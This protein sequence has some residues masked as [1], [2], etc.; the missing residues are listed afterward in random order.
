MTPTEIVNNFY[1]AFEQKDS[2]TMNSFLAENVKFEDPAFGKL[3]GEDVKYMWQFLTE[4]AKDFSVTFSVDEEK[5]NKV[6]AN[7][8]AQYTFSATGN[9]VI[10]H[11]NSNFELKNGKIIKHKDDF[12]LKKW[13][14]QSLGSAAGI[15]GA[16]FM[17]KNAIQK[18]SRNYLMKYKAKNALK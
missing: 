14:K 1:A 2:V 16:S 10:N 9:K 18:Q 13:V 3:E 15:F 5:G 4:N 11:V 6:K 8:I 17:M 12:D 7:W